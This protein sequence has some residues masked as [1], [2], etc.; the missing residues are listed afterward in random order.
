M[1]ST[2]QFGCKKKNLSRLNFGREVPKKAGAPLSFPLGQ[3]GVSFM[4][5]FFKDYGPAI[6]PALAFLL[7][8]LALVIT[9]KVNNHLEKER[10][11]NR[12]KQLIQLIIE[13]PPPPKY[14][15][16]SSYS[17]PIIPA[18]EARKIANNMFNLEIFYNQ[19]LAS[20]VLINDIEEP[21][22]RYGTLKEI[23]QFNNIKW[24][25][26]V[27]MKHIEEIKTEKYTP[28]FECLVSDY[29]HLKVVCTN[30]DKVFNY[31]TE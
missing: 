28:S 9:Y 5:K 6:G 30:P 24:R 8:I 4:R 12:F 15:P 10:T 16:R 14:F 26:S 18:N 31:Y 1:C 25:H 27:L 20:K 29:E 21:I 17:G 3:R 11:L 13:S 19:L 22:V 23:R 7:G 2:R